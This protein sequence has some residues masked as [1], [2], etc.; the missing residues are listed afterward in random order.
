MTHLLDL[1]FK[2]VKSFKDKSRTT[3]NFCSSAWA[4]S[5]ASAF[6]S[7]FSCTS[8]TSSPRE[9]NVSPSSPSAPPSAQP[10]VWSSSPLA[11]LSCLKLLKHSQA[12]FAYVEALEWRPNSAQRDLQTCPPPLGLAK[13]ASK[14]SRSLSSSNSS[15]ACARPRCSLANCSRSAKPSSRSAASSA[16]SC[17]SSA[18]QVNLKSHLKRVFF[19]LKRT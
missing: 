13:S 10:S 16:R 14:A 19:L 9:L 1:P 6:F 17:R 11:D 3:L 8:Q 18:S 2:S 4:S 12:P 5:A 15:T 7:C